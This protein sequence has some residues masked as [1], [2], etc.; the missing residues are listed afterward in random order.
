MAEPMQMPPM[1]QAPTAMY[2]PPMEMPPMPTIPNVPEPMPMQVIPEPMPM[3]QFPSEQMMPPTQQGMPEPVQQHPMPVAPEDMSHQVASVSL[4]DQAR[5]ALYAGDLVAAEQAYIAAL[6]QRNDP[7][8]HGELGNV[9]FSQQNW[10]AASRAYAAAIEGLS[11]KG[12]YLQA[13]Y[14]LG[15]L[16]QIDPEMGQQSMAVLRSHMYPPSAGQ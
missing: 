1:M 2:Q 9:Y 12:R 4:V 13:Q 15:F 10:P 14:V 16:M 7:D 6:A 5:A 11:A 8:L 3:V